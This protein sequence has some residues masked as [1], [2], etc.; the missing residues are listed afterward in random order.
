MIQI[1]ELTLLRAQYTWVFDIVS[2]IDVI[3]KSDN[4]DKDKLEEV[5]YL[6]KQALKAEGDQT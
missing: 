1:D 2:R 3:L 5:T 6:I 4:D